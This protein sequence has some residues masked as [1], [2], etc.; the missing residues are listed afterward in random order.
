MVS[1]KSWASLLLYLVWADPHIFHD[2]IKSSKKPIP[3][4]VMEKE[5]AARFDI[6]Y[7]KVLIHSMD[8]WPKATKFPNWK[9]E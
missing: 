4:S 3:Q 7:P 1:S 2:W 9:H 5:R 6:I 8:H